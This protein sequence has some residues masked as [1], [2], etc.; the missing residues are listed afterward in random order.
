MITTVK[1][2]KL[3]GTKPVIITCECE[4][5]P[6]NGI[7]LVGLADY[8][9]KES[10]LRTVTAMQA[11]GYRIP[12][13]KVV[14]NLSPA[15]LHK[16][17][18][19]YDLA[20][21][22]AMIAATDQEDLPDLGKWLVY[23][24]IGLD[25]T[26]RPVPG[27]LQAVET[28]RNEDIRG[29][30]IPATGA[31]AVQPFAGGLPVYAAQWLNE[32]V[33]IIR[34]PEAYQ[35]VESLTFARKT[36]KN[37]EYSAYLDIYGNEGARRAMLIAAAGG[38]NLLLAG[39]VGGRADI[40]AKAFSELLPP[41]TEKEKLETALIYSA[42]GT[43]FNGNVRPFRAPH[44]NASIVAL[45]GGG[46]GE[47]IFPGEVSLAHNGVLLISDVPDWSKAVMEVMRAPIEDKKVTI[48][49][50]KSKVEIKSDFRL[51]LTTR[52][53]PC[54]YYGQGERCTCTPG[55]K[56]TYLSRLS[57]PVYDHV[58][59]QAFVPQMDYNRKPATREEFEAARQTVAAAL[60]MQA[61]RY[62]G[63]DY[64]T[65]AEVPASEIDRYC[66]LDD[67]MK[68]LLDNIVTRLGLSARAYSRILRIARTIADTEGSAKVKP[69][70]IGEAASYRF[71]DRKDLLDNEILG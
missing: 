60:R 28:A 52:M 69:C 67:E 4:V 6:G 27:M 45:I 66:N 46:S 57:G 40:I 41:M 43:P 36:A 8:A 25:G 44:H 11:N 14:I 64:R 12:G 58:D 32:A 18:S 26:L 34:D 2:M 70:H 33:E 42:N 55:T 17:G 5:V 56:K 29:V 39:P 30:I 22:L 9:V 16:S 7:H 61:E 71:L 51:V 35:T 47:S 68:R 65:N 63:K 31:E 54:G 24:E 23:G 21:A 62:A 50:L 53:C 59:I 19:G 10:L 20:I 13:K 48:S 1:T 15:D 3:A 38:H 49:R 37:Q